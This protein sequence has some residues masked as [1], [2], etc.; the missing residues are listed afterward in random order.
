M[1]TALVLAAEQRAQLAVAAAGGILPGLVPQVVGIPIVVQL[2]GLRLYL[3]TVEL[4]LHRQ[5]CQLSDM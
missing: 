3:H 4:R 2:A 1:H 5:H